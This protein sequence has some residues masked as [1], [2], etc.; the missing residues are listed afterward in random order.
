VVA[1][2]GTE[3]DPSDLVVVVVHLERKS[4]KGV[5]LVILQSLIPGA[6]GYYEAFKQRAAYYSQVCS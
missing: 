5:L 2:A 3:N 6:Y 1:V 4:K